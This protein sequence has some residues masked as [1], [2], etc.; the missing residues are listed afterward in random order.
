MFVYC[1]VIN[2]VP[3]NETEMIENMHIPIMYGHL[4]LAGK[5]M[6]KAV[7]NEGYGFNALH[8]DVLV[9]RSGPLK[10]FKAT[11]V[12]K[13]TYWPAKNVSFLPVYK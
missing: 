9:K 12:T 10:S 4:E 5:I 6:E 3:K 2:K 11:S 13:K 8:K 1:F 7:A